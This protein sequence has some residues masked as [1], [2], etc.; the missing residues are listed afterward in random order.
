MTPLRVA[1]KWCEEYGDNMSVNHNTQQPEL[2]LK[3]ESNSICHH[4]IRESVAMGKI[5]TAHIRTTENV[6]NFGTQ[7]IPGG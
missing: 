6:A 2:T 7:V 4:A 1:L 5:V 3:K